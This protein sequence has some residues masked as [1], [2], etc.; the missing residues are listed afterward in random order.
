MH[1]C[2]DSKRASFASLKTYQQRRRHCLLDM[3]RQRAVHREER[4]VCLDYRVARKRQINCSRLSP[5]KTEIFERQRSNNL[6]RHDTPLCH[7]KA[8]LFQRGTSN[9]LWCVDF[10]SGDANRKFC[11]CDYRCY[12]Q[13]S[14]ISR[15]GKTFNSTIHGSLS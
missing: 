7:A 1:S 6:H 2:A 10:Y 3:F 11:E 14:T 15:A 4:M 8:N 12:W 13:P 5:R 9:R